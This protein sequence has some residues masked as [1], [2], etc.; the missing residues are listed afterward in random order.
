[1]K[2]ALIT[3]TINVPR[4]LQL[5]RAFDADVMFFVAADL[6]TPEATYDFCESIPNCIYLS[7]HDQQRKNYKSSELIGWK[8]DSRRNF[9]L[10]EAMKW[11]PDL[12]MSC[13][14]DMLP[15]SDPF[16]DWNMLFFTEWSGLK[17]GAPKQWFD[18]SSFA[19]PPTLARGIPYDQIYY[20]EV[21]GAC[22]V[23]IGAA[24]GIILGVPDTDACTAI[25]NRP[26]VTGVTD[27]LRSGFVVDPAAHAVFNSQFTIFRAELAPAFAQFYFA[28][29][30][31]TDIFASMLMRR[32]MQERN[33]YTFYGPP[34]AYH[35]RAPR[36]LLN[37][38]KAER[39]GVDHIVEYADY[40]ARAPLRAGS[41][42]EQCR[43]LVEGWK[44]P[45]LEAAMA[46][47]ED[48]EAVL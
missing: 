20:L 15:T 9:A 17:L 48:C 44:G 26:I 13:D 36:P 43:I 31:N 7:A 5:Y 12:I 32:I 42:V 8:T 3:T 21:H 39:Y 18:H 24:Q 23:Q 16:F 46:W 47:Y 25:A 19:L 33:L 30:R 27:I 22:N 1:V 6:K 2:V 35:A 34:M 38:L 41:V 4:V 28:Q 14:D 29:Q 10:L 11:K 45:E 40:L 37:D